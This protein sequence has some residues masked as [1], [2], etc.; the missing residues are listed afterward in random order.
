MRREH[1][2]CGDQRAER[3]KRPEIFPRL[4][5]LDRLLEVDLRR[6]AGD[7][8][9]RRRTQ[10]S[11]HIRRT[12]CFIRQFDD[13]EQ[14]VAEP[15][16]TPLHEERHLPERAPTPHPAAAVKPDKVKKRADTERGETETQPR[17]RVPHAIRQKLQRIRRRE[18]DDSAAHGD[19][20]IEPPESAFHLGKL[21]PQRF[22]KEQCVSVVHSAASNKVIVFA[23]VPNPKPDECTGFFN[24]SSAVVDADTRRPKPADFFEMQ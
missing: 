24:G 18:R 20:D 1:A 13:A 11:R 21:T 12:F 16:V 9:D 10:G 7:L 14:S 6:F 22:G 2:R 5:R 19:D 15:A 8:L 4:L 17:W 23:V 3:D